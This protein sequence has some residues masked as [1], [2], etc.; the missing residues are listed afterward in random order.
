MKKK[1]VCKNTKITIFINQEGENAP[2][3]PPPMTSLLSLTQAV[4]EVHDTIE[5]SGDPYGSCLHICVH[6]DRQDIIKLIISQYNI[7]Y[8]TSFAQLA[9]NFQFAILPFIRFH[10]F[11]LNRFNKIL[12]CHLQQVDN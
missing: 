2:L 4:R 7:Y 10:K 6:Q 3:A 12:R 1:I 8:K 5:S 11:T 9:A